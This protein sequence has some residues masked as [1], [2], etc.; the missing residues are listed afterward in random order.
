MIFAIYLFFPDKIGHSWIKGKMWVV[1]L[2]RG[3]SKREAYHQRGGKQRGD[4]AWPQRTSWCALLAPSAILG[5]PPSLS[6]HA[7]R[8]PSLRPYCCEQ[9]NF[10]IMRAAQI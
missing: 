10:V 5:R 2:R 9:I 7:T 1:N 3:E 8:F 4:M 6:P